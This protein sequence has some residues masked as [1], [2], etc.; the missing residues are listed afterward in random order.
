MLVACAQ[1]AVRD[2]DSEA[3]LERSVTAILDAIEGGAGL[4]VLPSSLTPVA[5]F[6]PASMLSDSPRSWETRQAHAL[7]LEGVSG[8]VRRL[9]RRWPARKRGRRLVQLRGRRRARQLSWALL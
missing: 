8:E 7:G 3:N 9:C 5:N 1:Y 6:P 2:G 4:V